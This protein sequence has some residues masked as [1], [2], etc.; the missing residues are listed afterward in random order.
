MAKQ[1]EPEP[2][3]LH[4]MGDD[5]VTSV[6]ASFAEAGV[7]P[8]EDELT[9]RTQAAPMPP[10]DSRRPSLAVLPFINRSELR[11]DDV[12]DEC[13]VEDL[14]AALSL[15][16]WIK[17]VAA[18]ATAVCRKAAR[19]LRQIGRDLGAR[20][21]LEGNVRWVGEDLRVTA[22]LVEAES[23]NILWT[24]KF[25]RRALSFRHCRKI[26]WR[27][28]RLISA[29]KWSASR[30]SMRSASLGKLAPGKR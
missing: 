2:S 18:S 15:S 16:P 4:K 22:Q 29:C 5:L 13:M 28:S 12:F 10:P 26:S 24:Q 7:T 11:A 9:E 14:T 23:E 21:L 6:L 1:G 3:W 27:R 19:D 17:V 20:Y 25:D 8:T 30:S